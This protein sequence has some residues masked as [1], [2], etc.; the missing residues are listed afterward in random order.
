MPKILGI[1]GSLRRGSFNTALLRA[2]VSLVEPGTELEAATLHGIPL[3]DGDLE[4]S[5]GVPQAVQDLKARLITADGLLLVTPEY[6]GGLPGVFKNGLDWMSRP[7]A[8]VAKVFG[9]RPVAVI[10]ASP[11]PFGTV[12]AQNAWLPTLRAL[13]TRP[14]WGGRVVVPHAGKVFN[15]SAELVDDAVRTQLRNFLK[16]FA[17]FIEPLQH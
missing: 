17:A 14:Y 3:Y 15:E 13:G 16:G 1:S 7:P 11:G 12:S 6:N 10:G 2:A 4:A 8:D 9:G 5:Q